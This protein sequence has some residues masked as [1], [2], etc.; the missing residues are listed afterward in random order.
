MR[1]APIGLLVSTLA[2]GAAAAAESPPLPAPAASAAP[3]AGAR[4]APLERLEHPSPVHDLQFGVALLPGTGFRSIFPYKDGVSCGKTGK[5]VC[6]GR[7]PFFL[8]VQPSFGVGDH[9]DV[10]VDLRFGIEQDFTNS[11]QFAVAPGVRYWVDP[12]QDF[13]FF[14]T[15]QVAYDTTAQHDPMVRNND[16]ALRN[17][18]GLMFDVMRNFG[19]YL[20]LGATIG[21]VRWL[22]FEIDGGAGVQA[23]F[24]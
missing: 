15:I 7:L 18:N 17:S 13:K 9:W 19:V 22:R 16:F 24:P 20:Q 2:S 1:A 14:A 23:R 12:D 6:T 8:D 4:P 21:F 10:L 3:A 5:R 11:H